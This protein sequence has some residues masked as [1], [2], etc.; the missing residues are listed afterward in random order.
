MDIYI[1]VK[2]I[3]NDIV[4]FVINKREILFFIFLCVCSVFL[5]KLRV[6]C[7]GGGLRI[8]DKCLMRRE[9]CC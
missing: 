2:F 9:N 4:F 5:G 3:V 8:R 6:R 1:L 7:G